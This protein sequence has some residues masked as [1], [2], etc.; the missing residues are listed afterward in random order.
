MTRLKDGMVFH[1]QMLWECIRE[2]VEVG[3]E[4]F[5]RS[6]QDATKSEQIV[7]LALWWLAR[8]DQAEVGDAASLWALSDAERRAAERRARE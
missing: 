6:Y 5:S 1:R 7:M 8:H 3:I 4:P 2:G